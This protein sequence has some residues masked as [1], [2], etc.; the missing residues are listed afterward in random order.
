MKKA[1]W[2][3]GLS[4]I[5]NDIVESFIEQ[6][7]SLKKRK[8]KRN[9]FI[10]YGAIA[11]CL[12][13]IIGVSLFIPIMSDSYSVVNPQAPSKMPC[14]FGSEQ[15]VGPTI[16]GDLDF[17]GISVTAINGQTVSGTIL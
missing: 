13:L 4:L 6:K 12:A 8:R 11:A 14:F 3:E 15:S 7:E 2:N 9:I 5:D 10:R 17:T 1:E 16:E